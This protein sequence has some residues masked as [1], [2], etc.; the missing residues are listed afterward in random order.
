METSHIHRK[1]HFKNKGFIGKDADHEPQRP[2]FKLGVDIVAF[3]IPMAISEFPLIRPKMLD[4][5]PHN[6]LGQK[7]G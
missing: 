3:P 1:L 2:H 4:R 6:L 5:V 7:A